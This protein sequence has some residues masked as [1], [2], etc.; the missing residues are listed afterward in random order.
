MPIDLKTT[1]LPDAVYEAVRASILTSEIV[2]GELVTENSVA[3]RYGIARPTAKAA[4][5]RLVAVGLL[6][7]QA[8][9]VARVPVLDRDD[10]EDLYA[11]RILV[12]EATMRNLAAERRIPVEAEQAHRDL[13]AHV[14]NDDRAA[15]ARDDIA[16]HRALA[17]GQRSPRL[18]RM[19]AIIMGEVELCIGQVQADRLMLPEVIAEH[20][21]AILEAIRVGDVELSGRLVREHIESAREYLLRKFD[22]DRLTSEGHD[23][24]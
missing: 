17:T 2:R 11:N 7:R 1:S 14:A 24:G 4:I 22:T 18:S 6:R 8:H 16:F 13:L 3:L 23:H 21:A 12:E 20:H 5:E 9:K 10:I 19:H 15:L